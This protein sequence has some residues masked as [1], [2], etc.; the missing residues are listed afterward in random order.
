MHT[1][2]CRTDIFCIRRWKKKTQAFPCILIINNICVLVVSK[3]KQTLLESILLY[4]KTRSHVVRTNIP[5]S[6]L[7]LNFQEQGAHQTTQ[8]QSKLG[9]SKRGQPGKGRDQFW[10]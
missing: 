9:N 7:P 2:Q 10:C 5:F 1:K 3:M 8:S 6:S 4:I